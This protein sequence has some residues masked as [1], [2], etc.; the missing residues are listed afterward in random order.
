LVFSAAFYSYILLLGIHYPY[1][2]DSKRIRHDI[3]MS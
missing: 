2:V 1:M 3:C